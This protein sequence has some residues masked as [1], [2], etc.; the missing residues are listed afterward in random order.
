MRTYYFVNLAQ[1]DSTVSLPFDVDY[2]KATEFYD[3]AKEMKTYHGEPA[4]DS[5]ELYQITTAA[6]DS[7]TEL[8]KKWPIDEEIMNTT[9]NKGGQESDPRRQ[10]PGHQFARPERKEK[11]RSNM[12]QPRP[13]YN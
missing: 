10:S 5:I 12:L 9:P 4:F 7:L 1:V 8:L 13:K 6:H 2:S 3:A 11:R